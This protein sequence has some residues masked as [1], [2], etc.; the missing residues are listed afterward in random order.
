MKKLSRENSS[1]QL[2][3]QSIQSF[4]EDNFPVATHTLAHAAIESIRELAN[5][6]GILSLTKDLEK[7]GDFKFKDDGLNSI[8]KDKVKSS[9]RSSRRKSNNQKWKEITETNYNFF[10]HYTSEDSTEFNPG[11]ND[12][13]ILDA[14]QLF[15]NCFGEIHPYMNL[16]LVWMYLEDSNVFVEPQ[17]SQY[18]ELSKSFPELKLDKKV[19]LKV[20]KKLGLN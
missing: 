1:K 12:L 20:L 16:F 19:F 18:E 4:F 3:L 17:K 8:Y 5:S 15:I 14:I 6:K 10:K 13:L 11:I 2:I 9:G 7:S